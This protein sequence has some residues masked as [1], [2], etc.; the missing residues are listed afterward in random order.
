MGEEAVEKVLWWMLSMKNL[1]SKGQIIS[2][3]A[4]LAM[5]E[6]LD[7]H[8]SVKMNFILDLKTMKLL[9][10]IFVNQI[11]PFMVYQHHQKLE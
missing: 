7:M 3:H 2:Q 1:A 6:S 9:S 8:L 5:N 10:V 11:V 4:N